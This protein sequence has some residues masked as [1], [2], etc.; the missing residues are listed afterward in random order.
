V[1][2][3]SLGV[4]IPIIGML[5]GFFVI[6]SRSDL[7]RALAQRLSGGAQDPQALEGELRE[8]RGEVEAI[9]SELLETQERLDFTE[10]VLAGVKKD[11]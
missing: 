5:I 11:G 10:R 7:G 4:L 3:G 2:P 8:L 6:F 1:N 9:R